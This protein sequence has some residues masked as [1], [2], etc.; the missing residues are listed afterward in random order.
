MKKLFLLILVIA[1][2]VGSLKARDW[3][4]PY[5]GYGRYGYGRWGGWRPYR[6]WGGGYPYG[7]GYYAS[8][9]VSVG[10]GPFGFGIW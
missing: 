9:G 4:R 8:P 2:T 6:R 10:V 5:Y 7:Y 1:S 3:R